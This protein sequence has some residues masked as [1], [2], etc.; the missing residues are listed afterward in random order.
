MRCTAGLNL[1]IWF[2]K[3]ILIKLYNFFFY[4]HFSS[5]FR[6]R[7]KKNE[8]KRRKKDRGRF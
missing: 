5:F 1:Q 2:K 3:V 7:K 4:V 6:E 8:P